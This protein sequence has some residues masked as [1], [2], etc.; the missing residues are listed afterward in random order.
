MYLKYQYQGITFLLRSKIFEK[1]F[2][3]GHWKY[4]L[5]IPGPKV[6]TSIFMSS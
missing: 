3:Q 2:R 4:I 5:S 6:G 1:E